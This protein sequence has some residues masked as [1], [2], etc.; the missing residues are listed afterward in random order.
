MENTERKSRKTLSLKLFSDKSH[1]RKQFLHRSWMGPFFIFSLTCLVYVPALKNDFIWD[2]VLYISDNMLIRSLSFASINKMLVSFH[3]SNWHPVT[4]LSLAFDYCFW[5]LD[6]F[7]YHLTNIF[8][9]GLNALLVFFVTMQ[10]L[11]R[12]K[13]VNALASQSPKE[14]LNATMSLIAAGATAVLFGL[15]PIHVESV[16]W[17]S[18]RKD[19]LCALFFLLTISSYLTY[20]ASPIE[21][22]RWFWFIVCVVLFILALMSK[23]MAVTLPLTL[24]LLDIYPLK[25]IAFHPL[26]TVQNLFPLLEKIPFLML[27]IAS[28]IITIM[29]QHAGGAVRSFDRFP[30]DA[31]LLN[32]TRSLVFYLQKIFLPLKLVPFY[33]FP[34]NLHWLEV[35]YFLSGMLFL[36]ITA[37]CLWMLRQGKHLPFT[38][39][40]YYVI[41]LLPTLGIIQVGGQAAADRY[42]YLPSLGIFMLMGLGL[43]W[44][45]DKGGLLKRKIMLG[46]VALI[47]LSMPTLLGLLTIQQIRLW[48]NSE[49]FWSYV[50][51]VFPFPKS[52]PLVHYNLGN[53]YATNGKLDR[54]VAEYKK[55]LTLKPL[56]AEAH[57]NLGSVYAL[58]GTV[59]KAFEEINQALSIRPHYAKA[60]N[61]LGNIYLQQG[62]LDKAISQYN[63]TLA[64]KQDDGTSHNNLA[65]AYYLK[66]DYTMARFHCEK[67]FALGIPVNPELVKFLQAYR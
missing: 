39:W 34:T 66:G 55:A 22:N 47:V 7:G 10:L 4:W 46:G 3:A 57:N 11:T 32:A 67:A 19:L 56:Y 28:S 51:E 24:I 42:T 54:A 9:H 49:I 17:I 35:E 41:T 6:P 59:N 31:R 43:A 5:G 26:T 62:E 13:T 52:D 63:Q 8:L 20:T 36:A 25:R 23:P 38:A 27:C 37:I 14:P 65:Y 18:E 1:S 33:P 44:I 45:L 15:H 58:Q 12:G 53:A 2:D 50:T 16:V 40:S 60:H 61:N 64:I 29:A 48:N 30:V 21:R